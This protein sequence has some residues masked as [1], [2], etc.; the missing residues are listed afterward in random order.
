MRILVAART[1]GLQAID[2]PYAKIRDL[3]GYRTVARRARILG[4]D[5]KWVLHP[6]QIDIANEV[7]A[8]SREEYERAEQILDTYRKATDVDLAGAVM[9]G[10]EMIDEAT[11]K[12]AEV[13][14]TRGRAAGMKAGARDRR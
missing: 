7:F 1:A 11:R 6:G 2:G 4:F 10:D 12:M 5:G 9:F 3:D 14:A 8:P 13:T